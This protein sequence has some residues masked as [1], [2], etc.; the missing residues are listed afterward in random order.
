[1]MGNKAVRDLDRM[2]SF[3]SGLKYSGQNVILVGFADSTGRAESS[4]ALSRNRAGAVA[5]TKV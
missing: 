2:T 5:S 3:P 1:M 4:L